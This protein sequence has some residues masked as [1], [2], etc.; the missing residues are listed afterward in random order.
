MRLLSALLV[1]ATLS[2]GAAASTFDVYSGFVVF[3]D[4]L[5]DGGNLFTLTSNNTNVIIPAIPPPYVGPPQYYQGRFSDGPVWAD[6]IASEFVGAGKP[7]INYAFGTSG[8]LD[9]GLMP[10]DAVIPDLGKQIADMTPSLPL[11]GP[12]VLATVWTGSNDAF[13]YV[14]QPGSPTPE[15]AAAAVLDGIATLVTQGVHDIVAFTL[16]DLGRIPRFAMF[17]PLLAD[18][19][20][21]AA[22]R[23]NDA[24]LAGL[25]GFLPPGVKID[26]V[27][28]DLLF[29]TL[30]NDPGAYG[31]TEL[32]NPCIMPALPFFTPIIPSPP[33]PSICPDPTGYAF[34]D[35]NHPSSTIHTAIAEEFEAVLAAPIPLP[36]GLP[37]AATGMFLLFV[38]RRRR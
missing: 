10:L 36:A 23:F 7:T 9:Y 33:P 28:I 27:R 13:R 20:T 26:T 16:P 38:I 17:Q 30:F 21:E 8:A 22:D 35:A 24:L 5:S 6:H 19:A 14:E 25:A 34:F 37:L 1:G 29:D 15:E 4:S 18:A 11:L 3:G 12:K 2:G 32:T 31:I